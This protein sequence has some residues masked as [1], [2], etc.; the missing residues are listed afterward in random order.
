MNTAPPISNTSRGDG[1]AVLRPPVASIGVLGWLRANLFSTWYNAVLTIVV[2]WF[3]IEVIPP[4]IS[5]ALIT[6]HFAAEPDA[7]RRAAGACWGFVAEKHRLMLFG[8][9]P[10]DQHWRPLIAMA[11]FIT[12]LATSCNRRYWQPLLGVAWL[13]GLLIM[14]VLMWGGVL[15]LTYVENTKW[16]G[17]PLTLILS[18]VGL[19]VAF[20]LGVILALGRQSHLPVIRALSIAYIEMVRGVPLISVLFMASVMFPLFLPEGLTI[21]KLLR[22]QVGIILFAAAYLAESVRGGLQAVP[23]GQLEAADALGLTYWQKMRLVV[24]PQALRIT[25]PSLVNNFI[26]TFKDTSLV[27]IIGLFDLLGAMRAGLNDAPWRS[28]Y[29][30]GYLFIAV[31]YFCFS[32]FMSKYS[33]Y[34]E[35]DMAEY[36]G[37]GVRDAGA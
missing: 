2:V 26:S 5:W 20:P 10:F 12:L 18:V 35:R 16:G 34:L 9:Y 15:G 11:V 1:D 14:G 30:E 24:L 37:T 6:A 3:L 13:A 17:L 25:I 29:I 4:L 31:I 28:F 32:F 22:A 8:T 7:C 36:S 21:D 27:V 33:Q 19:V 23:T